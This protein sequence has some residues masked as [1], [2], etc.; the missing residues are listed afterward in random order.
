MFS[1][2]GQDT[3]KTYRISIPGYSDKVWIFNSLDDDKRV[4]TLHKDTL[5]IH[6]LIEPFKSIKEQSHELRYLSYKGVIYRYQFAYFDRAYFHAN[7]KGKKL[8]L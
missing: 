4:A 3:S 2:M 7:R 8:C 6:K 1:A 5:F